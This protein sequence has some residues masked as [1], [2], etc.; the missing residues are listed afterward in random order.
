MVNEDHSLFSSV[1]VDRLTFD[2][3]QLARNGR[4]SPAMLVLHKDGN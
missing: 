4:Y 1:L 2:T 3:P